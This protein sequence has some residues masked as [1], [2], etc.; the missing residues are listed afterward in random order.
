MV[1]GEQQEKWVALHT[2]MVRIPGILPG[3]PGVYR[4]ECQEVSFTTF[5]CLFGN[6]NA[7]MENAASASQRKPCTIELIISPSSL[8]LS[9]CVYLAA[10]TIAPIHVGKNAILEKRRDA[11]TQSRGGKDRR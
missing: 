2:E 4:A 10:I 1:G 8:V 6:K 5:S 9:P 3:V 11:A 7:I